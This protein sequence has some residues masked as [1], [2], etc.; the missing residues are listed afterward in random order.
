SGINVSGNAVSIQNSTIS[1]NSAGTDGGVISSGPLTIRNS[2]IVGNAAIYEGVGGI[3]GSTIAIE[4]SIVA[5]NTSVWGARDI[6]ASTVN[7][8]TSSIFN[9]AGIVTFN[10]L[11]GNRPE[12]ENPRLGPLQANGGP[13]KT[14]A[15]LPGSPCVNAGS[16]PANL[17]TDQRGPGFPRVLNG[18]PDMGAFEGV[19]PVPTATVVSLPPTITV[20]GSTNF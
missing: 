9:H 18:T 13:T 11:G 1:G 10:D 4:S 6:N 15:L 17:T 5:G 19:D 8:K 14:Q 20:P 12:G 16:N 7:A 3:Q 2:T